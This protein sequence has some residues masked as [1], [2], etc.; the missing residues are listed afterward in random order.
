MKASAL[1]PIAMLITAAPLQAQQ[2]QA[3]DPAAAA[4]R[5]FN[6]VAGWVVAAADKVPADKYEYRPV[7]TVRTFGQIVAHVADG[8][9]YYCSNGAG[10]AIQWSDAV[11]KT[12]TGKAPLVEKLKASVAAC[13]AVY[14]KPVAWLP[15]IDN[16]GHTNL[17]YGNIVTYMRMMGLVPPSS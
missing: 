6:E 4:R 13:D 2:P 5:S 1:I 15:L 3:N 9:N 11:E 17:H 8:L 10:K 14:G 7:A 16:V 12:V